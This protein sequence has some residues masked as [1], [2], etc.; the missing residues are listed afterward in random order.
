MGVNAASSQPPSNDARQASTSNKSTHTGVY[1]GIAIAASI[2]VLLAGMAIFFFKRCKKSHSATLSE[3]KLLQESKTK[4]PN[5]FKQH[6]IDMSEIDYKLASFSMEEINAATQDFSVSNHVKGSVYRGMLEDNMV[7]IKRIER[8][9]SKELSILQ[10]VHHSNLISLLGVC[11]GP[12][13]S[14]LVYPLIGKGSLK[15]W[16]HE[17]PRKENTFQSSFLTWS[18]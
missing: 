1:V 7:A 14:F 6:M 10:R 18:A 8:D 2:V 17:F 5:P 16:L 11:I 12:H 15:D 13:Q 3:V 4:L 9:L